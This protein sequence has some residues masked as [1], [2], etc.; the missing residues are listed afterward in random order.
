[1]RDERKR[2]AIFGKLSIGCF[3]ALCIVIVILAMIESPGACPA[4]QPIFLAIP[5]TPLF[6]LAGTVLGII[7][8]VKKEPIQNYMYGLVINVLL[9]LICV[10]VF[11][12]TF[13]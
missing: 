4:G 5:L 10:F 2:K 8:A 7:G 3:F 1:M 11:F 12:N 9:V 6:A 13:L